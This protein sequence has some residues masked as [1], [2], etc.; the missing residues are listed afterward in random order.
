MRDGGH[1]GRYTAGAGATVAAPAKL[2]RFHGSV[3]LDA[4]RLNRDTAN[5]AEA[6]VQHL[7]ALVNAHRRL[8]FA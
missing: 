4:A 7:V 1:D 3:E 5:V 2:G 6:V 8:C